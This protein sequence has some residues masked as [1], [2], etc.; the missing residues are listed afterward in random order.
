MIFLVLAVAGQY[1]STNSKGRVVSVFAAC[2]EKCFEICDTDSC[3]LDCIPNKCH[4]SMEE[5]EFNCVT[6]CVSKGNDNR[7]A[8]D[9]I[10][11]TPCH[12]SIYVD[13]SGMKMITMKPIKQ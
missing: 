3:L 8:M 6:E 11:E 2:Y 9:C 5:N 1:Y 4:S 12:P 10:L 7:K 13:D